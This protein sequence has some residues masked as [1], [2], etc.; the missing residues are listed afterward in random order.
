[1]RS[2]SSSLGLPPMSRVTP[3]RRCP[4]CGRGDWCLLAPD[5]STAICPRTEA[6][7]VSLV[8][9]AGW[10]HVLDPRAQPRP[11]VVP[12]LRPRRGRDWTSYV[13]ST[14]S[15]LDGPLGELAGMLGVSRRSLEMIQA[16]YDGGREAWTFPERDADGNVIGILVRGRAGA[17]K[18]LP[19]SRCGL[20]YAR[21]WHSATGPVLLVEGPSDT[22]AALTMG[23]CVL[24]RPSNTGGIEL[25][26]EVLEPVPDDRPVIVIGERDRK[27][28]GSWPGRAGAISTAT[29]LAKTLDRP[30]GWSLPPG[31]AK[32]TRAWLNAAVNIPEEARGERFL[33]GIEV[34]LIHPPPV[35]PLHVATGP[36]MSIDAWRE[37]MLQNRLR[38]LDAPGIYLDASP[39]GAGKSHVDFAVIMHLFDEVH[40]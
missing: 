20:V 18:R 12:K 13:N 16:G 14:Q 7:S 5:G 28:D 15:A 9:N 31:D 23:L 17:K 10:L 3:D 33:A 36:T 22:A 35:I 6:G 26:V 34:V 30:I 1:M 2:A 19:N 40:R 37:I 11:F 27:P 29:Q 4:I 8:G 25:L 21:N 38:S 32:D 24:G 39:T